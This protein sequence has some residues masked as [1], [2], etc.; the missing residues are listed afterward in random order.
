MGES[1]IKFIQC[2]L[3]HCKLASDEMS[4]NFSKWNMQIAL[5]QEPYC[6]ANIV[7]LLN[8]GTL[9]YDKK[10]FTSD[11]NQYPRACIMCKNNIKYIVMNNFMNRDMATIG[12]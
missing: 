2:N 10:I 11:R 9:I 5:L 7:R 8:Q 6:T 4:K 3:N 12:E 1:C